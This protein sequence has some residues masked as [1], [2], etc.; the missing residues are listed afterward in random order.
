MFTRCVLSLDRVGKFFNVQRIN[1][2]SNY[3]NF[4]RRFIEFYSEIYGKGPR[5]LAAVS[6][7]RFLIKDCDSI[8]KNVSYEIIIYEHTFK[9]DLQK[10]SACFLLV[11]S[12]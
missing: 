7:V 5:Y 3:R 10:F 12:V 1:L 4:D 2:R 8:K 9:T 11:P 6:N